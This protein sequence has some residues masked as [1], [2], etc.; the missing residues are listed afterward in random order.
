M[1]SVFGSRPSRDR[2]CSESTDRSLDPNGRY[3]GNA[4]RASGGSTREEYRQSLVVGNLLPSPLNSISI[5][6]LGQSA[7][8]LGQG[9]EDMIVSTRRFGSTILKS[10]VIVAVV[11]FLGTAGNWAFAAGPILDPDKIATAEVRMWQ[12]YYAGNLP[13]LHSEMVALLRAQFRLAP[14][15]AERIARSLT[16]AAMK[17]TISGGNYEQVVSPDLEVA[18]LQ[19]RAVLKLTFDPREAARAELAWWVARRT[20]GQD[21]PQQVGK[22]IARLYAILYG[23]ER[24]EFL[25]AGVL[26]AEAAQLRDRGGMDCDW[27]EVE[28]L[29]RRSYRV[30]VDAVR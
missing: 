10:V 3:H 18:Y 13:R 24:P 1:T 19:L 7:A 26:R 6:S 20:P 16:V 29:L 30:L 9:M 28:R 4:Y 21:N 27:T 22:R 11:A 23:R 25:E 5:G 2:I 17:F 12:A 15:D 8:C 14:A